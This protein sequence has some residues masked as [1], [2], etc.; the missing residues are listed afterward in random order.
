M[1]GDKGQSGLV[2]MGNTSGYNHA[3]GTSWIPEIAVSDLASHPGHS[4]R[5]CWT[6]PGPS[7]SP[8]DQL[9]AIYDSNP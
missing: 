7:S 8:Q 3:I 1:S 2:D 5:S 4:A 9:A 6:S